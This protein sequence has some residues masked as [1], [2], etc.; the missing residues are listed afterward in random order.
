MAKAWPAEAQT[1]TLPG[2]NDAGARPPRARLPDQNIDAVHPPRNS[3]T[4]TDRWVAGACRGAA[5]RSAPRQRASGERTLIRP[6]RLRAV[7]VRLRDPLLHLG[8]TVASN[9]GT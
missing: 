4:G 8:H 6:Q 9:T 1:R 2:H 7:N 5:M 3:G